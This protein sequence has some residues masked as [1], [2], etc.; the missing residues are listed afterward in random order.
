MADDRG[1]GRQRVSLRYPRL[2]VDVGGD[3]A[4]GLDVGR[5]PGGQQDADGEAADGVERGAEGCVPDRR[6]AAIVPNVT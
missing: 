5:A 2:D 4:E 3:I 1:G 6:A